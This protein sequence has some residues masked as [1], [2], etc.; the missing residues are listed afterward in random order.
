MSNPLYDALF[1]PHLGA[2]T[3]F[4]HLPDSTTWTHARFLTLAAKYANALR[5]HGLAPGD[6]LAVQVAK[7]PQALAL[8]AA[9]VQAGVA[10]LP[11][12]PA[13]TA[14][15]VAYFVDD[16]GAKLLICDPAE[17][18]ALSKAGAPT[19][20]LDADGGGSFADA[21]D[22]QPGTFE[23]A[24]RA[25]DD[26]AA[27]LY[28]SGTTGRSKGA[29]LTQTNLLSNA[30]VLTDLW[31]FTADDCLLHALPIFHTHGLFVATNVMLLAG[32]PMIF[33][34]RF[35]TDAVVATLPRATAMMGVPTFYTRLLD[36]TRLTQASTAHMRLF[37]SGSAPL[38]ADTHT[39]FEART[40]HRILERYGMTETNMTTSNP[41]T[42]NRRPGT[43]GQPL[44]GVEVKVCDDQGAPLP[45]GEIGM[46][47][48]RGPNVF[49]GY[50]QMPDKTAAELRPDGFFI[51]GDLA[52][53][54]TDGYVQIVGRNKDLII[55]GG[56]NIYPKEVELALDALPGVQESAVIGV[57][58][59]D[60]GEAV[61]AVVVPEPEAEPDPQ[62]ISAA[63]AESLARFK[64]P[65]H[66]FTVDALPRNTM[67]KVQKNR[68]RDAYAKTFTA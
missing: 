2:G 1:A 66:I 43:V 22:T 42:G 10:F 53:V 56:F 57:P 13:Y 61:V 34:P 50:W 45:T 33:L 31:Q 14:A 19:L 5:A 11:L 9:C 48:V 16:S 28:T 15:E 39:A 41:Y 47:E 17:Q 3:P 49:K 46:L 68:L 44:P 35:D 65:R 64:R 38:L 51:T 6:R 36:D 21:A 27:L 59:P 4:L 26:L 55:S 30:K 60:L 40:G 29:M 54:D 32:G 20:T 24:A 67:G 62:A 37:V 23:T 25:P 52:R 12:N 58:H 63:L 18:A 7:S 8:Y